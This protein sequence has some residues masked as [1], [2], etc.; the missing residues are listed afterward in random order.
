MNPTDVLKTQMQ[1][2]RGTTTPPMGQMLRSIYAGGGPM[3]FYAS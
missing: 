2:H 3:A 1:A